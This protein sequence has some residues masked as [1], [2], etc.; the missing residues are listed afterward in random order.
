MPRQA[1]LERLLQTWYDLENCNPREKGK[2]R[3]AFN[4]L[5]DDARAGTSLSRHDLIQAMAD[6][7]RVFKIAKDK[8]TRAALSQ[9]K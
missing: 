3:D 1:D 6:R 8:E 7:Y 4:R 5:L 2:L 9:L